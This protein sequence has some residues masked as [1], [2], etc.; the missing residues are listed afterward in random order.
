MLKDY[1]SEQHKLLKYLD[2]YKYPKRHMFVRAWTSKYRHFGHIT[3]SK[4]EAGHYAFKRYL[5][6]NRHDLLD[7]KDKWSVMLKVWRNNFN[8]KLEIA[9][10][11][12]AHELRVTRWSFLDLD[13]NKQIVPEAMKLLVKQL[14]LAKDT[15]IN[16]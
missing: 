7:L 5:Q 16:N 8:S 14:Y 6:G 4:G 12:P 2:N 1:Y 3:T 9:C 13:L 15:V 11:R 10:T